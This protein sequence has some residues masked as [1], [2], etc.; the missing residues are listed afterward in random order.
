MS[1]QPPQTPDEP[2]PEASDFTFPVDTA[3]GDALPTLFGIPLNRLIAF[4]GPYIAV[5]SGVVADWL[6]VHVHVLSSFHVQGNE[7]GNAV[8]QILVFGI[9][10]LVVWLGHQKWLDGY[11]KWAYHNAP[12]ALNTI[13]ALVV[14][15]STPADV[16]DSAAPTEVFE[17]E[18]EEATMD[19]MG[20][21]PEPDGP[22]GAK[23]G[24]TA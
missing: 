5:I 17:G 8:S 10:A 3:P 9:T 12:A 15:P 23:P 1:E 11:Q 13:E 2:E 18:K 16:R 14:P 20:T 6:I 19:S 7:I 21:G 4:A 22:V 24:D